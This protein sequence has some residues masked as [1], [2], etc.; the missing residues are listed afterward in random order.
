M[1]LNK[2]SNN[3]GDQI[4]KDNGYEFQIWTEKTLESMGILPKSM[5]PLKPFTK[6]KK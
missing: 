3:I 1:K 2:T 6:R 4:A 5:K